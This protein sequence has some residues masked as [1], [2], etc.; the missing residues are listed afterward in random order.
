MNIRRTGRAI[1]IWATA[2]IIIIVMVFLGWKSQRDSERTVIAQA[3]EHLATIARTQAKIIAYRIEHIYAELELL[4]LSPTIRER[5]SEKIKTSVAPAGHRPLKDTL[6]HL[7][8]LVGALYRLDAKGI[9]QG[10][11]PFEEAC[12]GTDLADKPGVKA[13]LEAHYK[14]LEHAEEAHAHISGI[15][16][17]SSGE[18]AISVCVP[19]FKETVFIGILRA[20]VYLDAVNGLVKGI[21]AGQKGYAWIIDGDGIM[22]AHPRSEHMGKN[23]ITIRR[24]AFPDYDWRELKQIVGRMSRGEEGVGTYRSA[25][26]QRDKLRLRRELVAFA[27]IRT[28]K[29]PWSLAVSMSYDEV[30]GPVKAHSRNI[31]IVTV[32]LMLGLAGAGLWFYRGE[33]EK[34]R[35]AAEAQSAQQLRSLNAEL[36]GEITNRERAQAEREKLLGELEAKNT[37]LERFT[38]AVSHDLKS[39]IV[40]IKGFLGLLREDVAKRDEEQIATDIDRITGAADKMRAL[41]DE[42]LEL[43]RVGRLTSTPESVPLGDLAREAAELVGGSIAEKGVAIE[44]APGLP[45]L[46]GDRR[47]LL[48]VLQNLLD[49][50]VKYMGDQPE[51]RI[52]VGVRQDG[53]ETVFY[54]RDNG[55]GIEPQYQDKVFGLFDQ[56]NPEKEGTG[57][58]LAMVKRVIEMHGGRIWIES[59]GAGQGSTFCFTLAMKGQPEDE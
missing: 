2:G 45:V 9:V 50:A 58:G 48:E 37:E 59:D 22:L 44:I 27:P 21:K 43:S 6:V 20:V 23:I 25:W 26:W 34:A 55:M 14:H 28:G 57:I 42:L 13:V 39:P 46:F 10:K 5:T 30:S 36:Q 19:V 15:F 49:N 8:D 7:Q 54:V 18:K 16:T 24:E 31:G 32:L 38:Y 29:R 4:A 33:K 3:Q 35:L 51:P 17:T 1:G 47:R 11:V 53:D 12:K 41:L 52:E 56:L 40:T